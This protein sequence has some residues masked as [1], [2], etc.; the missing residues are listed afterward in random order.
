MAPAEGSNELEFAD[1]GPGLCADRRDHAR[2][3]D[4]VHLVYLVCSVYLVY[5]LS[6]V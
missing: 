4:L 1:R 5:A 3:V 6:L 2:G